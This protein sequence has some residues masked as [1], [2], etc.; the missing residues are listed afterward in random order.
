[1]A[2]SKIPQKV[3]TFVGEL[4]LNALKQIVGKI[5]SSPIATYC[6]CSTCACG[7]CACNCSCNSCGACYCD[8]SCTSLE[9]LTESPSDVNQILDKL[10]TQLGDMAEIV[11]SLKTN[12]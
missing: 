12:R 1:M 5:G 3:G 7:A 11:K 8:C 9:D 6:D 4:E 10:Q 2:D